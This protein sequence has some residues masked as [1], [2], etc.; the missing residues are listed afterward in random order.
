MP[1]EPFFV[2]C[3]IPCRNALQAIKVAQS[4]EQKYS[5]A[6]ADVLDSGGN[7]LLRNS[8]LRSLE[9]LPACGK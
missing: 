6:S 1:I 4:V 5:D 3:V 8:E 9:V 2:R 7:T